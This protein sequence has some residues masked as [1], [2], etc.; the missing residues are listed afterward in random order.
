MKCLDAQELLSLATDNAGPDPVRVMEARAHCQQCAD[1]MTFRDTLAATGRAG[2]PSAPAALVDRVLALARDE[3]AVVRAAGVAAAG[4]T[5]TPSPPRPVPLGRRIFFPR[6]A[7]VAVAAAVLLIAV[8][9]VGLNAPRFAS[10]RD[11]AELSATGAATTDSAATPPHA[12]PESSAAPAADATAAARTADS[13]DYVTLA[14]RVFRLAGPATVSASSL[15]TAGVVTSAFDGAS[16]AQR[17]TAYYVRSERDRIL[18]ERVTGSLTAFEAVTRDFGGMTYQLMS[19]TD[20]PAYGLWPT[21]PARFAT[22][23]AEDGSPTFRLLGVDDLGVS[24]YVPVGG[25]VA[26]GFAVAPGLPADDP[27][28]GNPSWTWWEPLPQP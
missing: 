11:G 9:V 25:D 23:D 20:L 26:R 12:A 4:A 21:L 16:E 22:P 13:P 28:A 7:A 2:A 15:T 8:A 10:E 27:S 6:L 18:I 24:V 14:G 19:G 5:A 17:R 1:C 3:A